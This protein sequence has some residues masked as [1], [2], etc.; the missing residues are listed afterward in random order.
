MKIKELANHR[1]GVFAKF[2][3]EAENKGLR[4]IFV[5]VKEWALGIKE[6]LGESS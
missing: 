6:N 4:G 2:L 5:W 1:V 3:E